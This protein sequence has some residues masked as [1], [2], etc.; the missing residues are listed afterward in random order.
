MKTRKIV[1]N[2]PKGAHEDLCWALAFS[3]YTAEMAPPPTSSL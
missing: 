3:V 2:H 1:F